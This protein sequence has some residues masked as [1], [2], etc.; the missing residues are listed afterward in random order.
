MSAADLLVRGVTHAYG[1]DVTL[2]YPDFT[3]R[4]GEHLAITGPSGAGKT[5][6]LHFIAGLLTPTS[7]DVT[8]GHTR[9]NALS[10]AARDAYRARTVGYVFQDFHLMPGYTALENVMLGLGL[11]GVRGARARDAARAALTRLGL[12]ERAHHTPRQL[13]TGERQRVALARAVAHGPGLLLADEPT[14]H[15]DRARATQALTL[16]QDTARDLGATLIVVSHDPLV[17]DAFARHLH[18]GDRAA[19]A[20]TAVVA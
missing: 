20:L 16:L 14:A 18:V 12:G 8:Y 15:L 5:T 4:A 1:A 3:A 19:P 17:I 10:E 11:A 2:T 6:L 7:G 13:S 9:V